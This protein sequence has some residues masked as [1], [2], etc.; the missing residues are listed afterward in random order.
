MVS[1]FIDASSEMVNAVL[2]VFLVS[3][4]CWRSA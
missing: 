2:P 4:S 3:S 1:F